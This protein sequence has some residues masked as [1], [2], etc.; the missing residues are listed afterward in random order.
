MEKS[1]VG[2]QREHIIYIFS[3]ISEVYTGK[4]TGNCIVHV[5]ELHILIQLGRVT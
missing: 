3:G 5:S 2:N 1:E 4:T